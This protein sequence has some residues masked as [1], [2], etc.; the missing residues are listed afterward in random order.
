[1]FRDVHSAHCTYSYSENLS[2]ILVEIVTCL[3]YHMDRFDSPARGRTPRGA[4]AGGEADGVPDVGDG[5]AGVRRGLP[6]QH[7]VAGRLPGPWGMWRGY[8]S[9]E[10]GGMGH[11]SWGEMGVWGWE[12][13]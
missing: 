5:L 12:S 6:P 7:H 8:G 10:K 11:G 13:C 3:M 1:M 9:C 2:Q 4:D